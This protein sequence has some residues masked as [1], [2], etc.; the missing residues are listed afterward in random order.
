MDQTISYIFYTHSPC[1]NKPDVF[2]T[3]YVISSSGSWDGAA[4]DLISGLSN[5]G[6][7]TNQVATMDVFS[8]DPNSN[9]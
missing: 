7:H 3:D 1:S 8:A 4:Y 9:A 2:I 5:K 6:A